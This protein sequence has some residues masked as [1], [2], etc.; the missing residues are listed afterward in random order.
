MARRTATRPQVLL[1]AYVLRVYAGLVGL[2]VGLA[3]AILT[4]GP[5]RF[6]GAGFD[7]ARLLLGWLPGPAH[8]AW[9]LAFLGY[10]AALALTLSR[11]HRSAA[12]VLWFG[13][14]VYTF[15][16][17]GFLLSLANP[18]VAGGGVVAYGIAAYL[19]AI[20]ADRVARGPV[21]Q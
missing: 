4:G 2:A 21:E 14:A 19:H 11:R 6:S 15:Y 18:L 10:G 13:T 12:G 5:L 3:I 9:G 17:F 16:A 20:T 8:L 1:T 7:G